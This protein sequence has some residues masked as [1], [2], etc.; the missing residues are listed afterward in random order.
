MDEALGGIIALIAGIAFVVWLLGMIVKAIEWLVTSFLKLLASI[1]LELSA[2]FGHPLIVVMI[3]I[4]VG[5]LIGL[6]R[7]RQLR[8]APSAGYADDYATLGGVRL[9]PEGWALLVSGGT[10]VLLVLL[11]FA[12]R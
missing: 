11:G 8:G 3:A 1:F 6:A 12:E 10:L 7:H 9:V 5:A 2:L 4:A